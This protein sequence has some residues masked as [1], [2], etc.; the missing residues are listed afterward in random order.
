MF[1]SVVKAGQTKTRTYLKPELKP[2]L[3]ST[4]WGLKHH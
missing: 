1:L 2:V 4:K 3:N